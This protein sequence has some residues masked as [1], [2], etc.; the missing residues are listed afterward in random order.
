VDRRIRRA[1]LQEI[2]D[3]GVDG[4]SMSSCARRAQVSKASIYLRW[5]HAEA[6]IIDALA[7]VSTWPAVADLG[8]LEAELNVL[9]RWFSGSEAWATTQLLMRFAGEA[10]RH[11]DLFQTYQESTVIVGVKRVTEV[12]D[13]ARRRGEL[14]RDLDPGVLAVAFIGALSIS[15]QLA[16]T[17]GHR[18]P[19]KGRD[20]VNGFIAL[21]RKP[22][23]AT[24]S[25]RNRAGT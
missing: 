10:A 15:L 11:P 21:R 18:L 16:Q 22:T 23:T 12:F 19:G 20:I 24:L 5:P 3:V 7:S 25:A 13:R 17:G 6:L 8:D 14:A 9:A 2:A 1:A 4:F